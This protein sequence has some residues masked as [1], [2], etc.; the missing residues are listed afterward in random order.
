M[1]DRHLINMIRLSDEAT[2]KIY[3]KFNLPFPYFRMR[4]GSYG[5]WGPWWGWN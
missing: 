5:W 3:I 2:G 4:F 1:N